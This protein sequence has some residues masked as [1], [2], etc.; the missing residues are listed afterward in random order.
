MLGDL[1][2]VALAKLG[3]ETSLVC[4]PYDICTA[5]L[6]QEAGGIVEA[7]DGSP[8]DVPLDTTTAVSWMGYAN[9]TLAD[10][11]RPILQRLM[12]QYF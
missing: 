7:A 5:M 2:P 9:S 8:L 6:L 3:F 4:H 10:Q 11:V 1:R 12:Q